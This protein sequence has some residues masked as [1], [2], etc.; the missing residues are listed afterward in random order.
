MIPIS[1]VLIYS[2]IL[3][4]IGV[5]GVLI[6]RNALI[7]LMS[8][9][10]MMNAANVNLIAFSR[11]LDNVAGQVFAIFVMCVAASEVAIG[12]AIAVALYRNKNSIQID[13]FNELKG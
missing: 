4:S 5:L 2:V 1:H 7:M 9:E 6:R 3:F 11:Y 12:L 10:L 13:H 8:L